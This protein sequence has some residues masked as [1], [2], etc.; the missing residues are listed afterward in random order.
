MAPVL[1]PSFRV[2]VTIPDASLCLMTRRWTSAPL[3]FRTV[4]SV[5]ASLGRPLA[6]VRRGPALSSP[7]CSFPR[8]GACLHAAAPSARL[9]R[10]P[11]LL[12]YREPW[13]D[14]RHAMAK[15]VSARLY[16]RSCAAIEGWRG[17]RFPDATSNEAVVSAQPNSAV[18]RER[19]GPPPGTVGR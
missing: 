1:S 9:Y 8:P 5:F 3:T 17:Y 10:L 11:V 2:K 6:A 14:S 4:S 18:L 16:R 13:S 12:K 15:R 7:A 19:P